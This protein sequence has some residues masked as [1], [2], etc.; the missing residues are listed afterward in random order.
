[1]IIVASGKLNDS[2]HFPYTYRSRC[3][4][5]PHQQSGDKGN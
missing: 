4:F 1:V 5:G 3:F 2:Q